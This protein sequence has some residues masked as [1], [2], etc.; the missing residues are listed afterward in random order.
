[1]CYFL[2][3]DNGFDVVPDVESLWN[4]LKAAHLQR[5]HPI[6]MYSQTLKVGKSTTHLKKKK[7]VYVVLFL[8]CRISQARLSSTHWK[9]MRGQLNTA[10]TLEG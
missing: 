5:V 6:E 10:A 3:I 4:R 1:M 7:I 8:H 9:Y 2:H